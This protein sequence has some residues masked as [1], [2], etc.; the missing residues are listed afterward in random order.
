MDKHEESY[1]SSPL[2][3]FVSIGDHET[4]RNTLSLHITIFSA[5]CEV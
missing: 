1:R 5:A 4:P 2:W 3:D